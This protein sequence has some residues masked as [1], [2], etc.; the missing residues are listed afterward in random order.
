M[1]AIPQAPCIVFPKLILCHGILT[2]MQII[3]ALFLVYFVAQNLA[4]Q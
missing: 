3:I 4:A 2:G 1:W